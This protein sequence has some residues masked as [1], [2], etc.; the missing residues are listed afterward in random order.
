SLRAAEAALRR[1]ADCQPQLR[2][3]ADECLEPRQHR[4]P[5]RALA[6]LRR[7]FGLIG[8]NVKAPTNSELMINPRRR[9]ALDSDAI[10]LQCMSPLRHADVIRRRFPCSP[11]KY[12]GEV[13]LQRFGIGRLTAEA[14]VAV[15][16]DH[17]QTFPPSSIAVV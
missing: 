12:F 1:Q 17:I 11:E 13:R 9:S 7:S 6:P 4:M 14:D 8:A 10:L 15:G 2:H 16:T 3:R 5:T